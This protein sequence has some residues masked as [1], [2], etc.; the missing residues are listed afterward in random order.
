MLEYN[1]DNIFV[2]QIKQLLKSFNLPKCKVIRDHDRLFIYKGLTYI[3]KTNILIANKTK[4]FDDFGYNPDDFIFCDVFDKN[5][6]ILNIT[7]TLP[8]KSNQYD[9]NTHKELGDYLRFVRDYENL[10]L[11]SMYNCFSGE[12]AKKFVAYDNMF[13]ST[14]GAY[15][16]CIV[17]VKFWKK[18]AIAIDCVFDIEIVAAIYENDN[19]VNKIIIG[20]DDKLKYFY[21]DTYAKFNGL[22]FSN[23]VIYD[24]LYNL[25]NLSHIPAEVF[26]R[27]SEL[28]LII[29]IPFLNE[30]S[31]VVTELTDEPTI[32]EHTKTTIS[33]RYMN[34]VLGDNGYSY[35][36]SKYRNLLVNYS[37]LSNDNISSNYFTS[38]SQLLQKNDSKQHPFAD[39]LMEYLTD[40]VITPNDDIISNIDRVQDSL[41]EQ[42]I[43]NTYTPYREYTPKLRLLIYLNAIKKGILDKSSDTF[44]YVDKDVEEKLIIE[45]T[46]KSIKEY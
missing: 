45:T 23:C 31:L 3:H 4:F 40:N 5:N 2:G 22:R 34:N 14:N 13:D 6:L 21:Q 27:E 35:Y 24:K 30:S 39:R 41:L 12:Y 33:K 36:P 9:Y 43:I 1:F 38:D 25:T 19:Q 44:G 46:N 32:D 8:I 16:L 28:K 7:H 15:K 26:S 18:Y 20:G 42:G 37:N 29:K 11:M 17:P 10:D